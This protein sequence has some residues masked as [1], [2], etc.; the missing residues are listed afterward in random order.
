MLGSATY[1]TVNVT[2][3]LTIP[4]TSTITLEGT[5]TCPGGA[6]AP[7]CFGLST[8]PDFSTCDLSANSFIVQNP[9]T[10]QGL[11]VNKTNI[12]IS[13]PAPFTN[14]FTAGN[15]NILNQKLLSWTQYAVTTTIDAQTSLIMRALQ[16]SIL[17]QTGI[18]SPSNNIFIEALAGQLIMA[19]ASGAALSTSTGTV[20]LIAGQATHYLDTVGG[21]YTGQGVIMSLNSP[22]I[23]L[24]DNVNS[25]NWLRTDPTQSYQCPLSGTALVTDNTRVSTTYGGDIVFSANTRLLSLAASGRIETVGLSLYCNSTIS[26]S[27]GQPLVL[28]ESLTTFIDIR[29][30]I[31]NT[32]GTPNSFSRG[33][34]VIDTTGLILNTTLGNSTSKLYTNGIEATDNSTIRVFSNT[35]FIGPGGVSIDNGAAPSTSALFTNRIDVV[36]DT[37]LTVTPD[38]TVAGT[39]GLRIDNGAGP[40][41]SRLRT[42]GISVADGS[43]VIFYNNVEIRGNLLVSGVGGGGGGT[44]SAPTGTISASGGSCCTSDVRVKQNITEVE[45]EDDLQRILGMPRRVSFKYSPEYLKTDSSARDIVYDGYIA[46]ELEEHGFDMMVNKQGERRLANGEVIKDF[47]TIQLERL[48]PY[49][50]GAIQELHREIEELKKR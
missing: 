45:P 30:G 7:N 44:I 9:S 8:C 26:T 41:T 17:L 38:V 28:G 43:S 13:S 36:D 18:G 46:Q 49:L 39:N 5:M 25:L 35:S 27:S 31:G 33:V 29:G 22:N 47:R 21:L 24:R 23:T 48:V 14:S 4:S 15:A 37:Q 20:G 2:T 19:G 40:S 50:V 32:G 42:N 34:L 12:T 11:I 16:G 6:L 10:L 1:S 3:A